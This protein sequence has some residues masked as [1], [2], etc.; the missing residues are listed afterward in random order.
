MV[1]LRLSERF[2]LE[3]LD[4]SEGMERVGGSDDGERDKGVLCY[5]EKEKHRGYIVDSF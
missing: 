4:D 5:D 3:A 2:S 1:A